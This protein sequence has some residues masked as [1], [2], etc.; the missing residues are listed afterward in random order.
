MALIYKEI[1]KGEFCNQSGD[2]VYMSLKRRLE[3]TLPDPV[4]IELKFSAP[5]DQPITIS[6]PDKGEYKLEPINGTECSIGL[7]ADEN[8]EL[9]DLYTADEREWLVLITG[10]MKFTGYL[11]PDSCSEPYS[12]KP[13]DVSISA[14]DAVGT[15]KDIPFQNE[16]KTKIKGKRS[17]REVLTLA[18]SKTG[19]KLGM[20][21][22]VNIYETSMTNKTINDDPLSQAFIDCQRFIDEEQNAFSCEEVIRSIMVRYS[23]RLRQF[24][25]EWQIV[26]I[27]ELI[28]G[29]VPARRF[30]NNGV[31]IGNISLGNVIDAG[32][33]NRTLRPVG[34]TSFDKAFLSSIAYY[35]YGYLG[36]TLINGDMDTWTSKP[37]GLPDGWVLVQ[38]GGTITATTGVRLTSQGEET[39]DYF[40]NISGN[41]GGRVENTNPVQIRANETPRVSLD[42]YAP[43]SL[44]LPGSPFNKRYL[45]LLIKSNNS[46]YFTNSGWSTNFGYYLSGYDASAAAAQNNIS[47]DVTPQNVD[48]FI[49]IGLLNLRIVDGNQTDTS[50]NNV[51][52]TSGTDAAIKPAI[53][54]FNKQTQVTNQTY[55]PEPILLLHGDD[56]NLQRTSLIYINGLPSS[57]WVYNGVTKTL[58]QWVANS[59]LILHSKPSRILEAQF[60]GYGEIGPNTILNVDLLGAKFMYLS[61]DFDL[62][63]QNHS[64]RFIQI[65]DYEPP[66]IEVQ[67]EDYGGAK[68]S[69]GQSVGAPNGV[70]NTSGGA[71]TDLNGYAKTTDLPVKA[72]NT[73]TQAGIN[74]S[75]FI[76]P[77]TLA[78]WLAWIRTQA[79]TI[80]GI[81]NFTARPTFNGGNLLIAADISGKADTTTVNM[82]LALKAPLASPTFTGNPTAPTPTAGDNDTS[83]ATTEFVQ[84]ALTAFRGSDKV[85]NK[86]SD[87]TILMTDFG[88][89]G[90]A[91]IYVDTTTGNKSITLPSV[92]N[93]NG[94]TVNVIKITSDVNSVMVVGT[95]NGVTN[96]FLSNQFDAGS[97]KSN[98]TAIYKF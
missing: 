93:L 71:Y 14:T 45:P 28:N 50:F 88:T 25:N 49:T 6:N 86:N 94:Y 52:I 40:I 90:Q 75:K 47:F 65:P 70:G 79:F 92:A 83:I 98:G 16:D 53:G 48:Y 23:A 15:L 1:Y 72:T 68:N 2:M 9:A 56:L 55:T 38:N 35:Q 31:L 69:A 27:P 74:D 81:W 87:Y 62:K 21:I 29:V 43:N 22:G 58:L 34:N 5:G 78:N 41:G 63:L 36:N 20:A 57:S 51:A 59:E 96:D 8:F 60:K 10:A 77:S 42:W 4:S 44:N 32:G 33:S 66:Y 13:Y 54:L 26:R 37:N 95:I 85:L 64:L 17:D 84:S 91:T 3:S 61:G 82:A 67:S 39:T 24:N 80:S 12:P 89:N 30:D 73:E 7:I 19:L 18:L 46:L 97:Y 76:T 11:I